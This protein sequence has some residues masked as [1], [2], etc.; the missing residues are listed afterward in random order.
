MP[1]GLWL[2]AEVAAGSSVSMQYMEA[3]YASAHFVHALVAE[4]LLMRAVV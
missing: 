1:M 3:F 2:L 4:R